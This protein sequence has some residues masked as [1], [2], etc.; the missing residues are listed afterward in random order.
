ML[1][2][3]FGEPTIKRRIDSMES[4][5]DQLRVDLDTLQERRDIIVVHTK[6]QKRLVARRYNTKERP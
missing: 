1:L 6:A 2:V 4:N 5:D 3:E